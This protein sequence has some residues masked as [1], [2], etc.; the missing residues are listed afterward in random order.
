MS[1]GVRRRRFCDAGAAQCF[2]KSALHG[3]RKD[4]MTPNCSAARIPRQ[5]L[6]REDVLPVPFTS[7]ARILARQR[8]RQVDL[9]VAVLEIDRVNPPRTLGLPPKIVDQRSGSMVTRS[10]KPLPS[11]T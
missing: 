3:L 1:E 11:R 8:K 4:V 5:P 6:R 10:R 7:G 9:A 2:V